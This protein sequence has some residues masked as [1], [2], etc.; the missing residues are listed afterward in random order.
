MGRTYAPFSFFVSPLPRLGEGLG[1]RA[2]HAKEPINDCN[3]RRADT[4]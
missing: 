1:V 2:N 4:E 3:I